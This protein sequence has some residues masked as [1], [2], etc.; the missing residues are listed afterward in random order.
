MDTTD[1]DRLLAA[2]ASVE[3]PLRRLGIYVETTTIVGTMGEGELGMPVGVI[4][5]LVGDAAFSQRVQDP[6]A[7]ATD[8]VFRQMAVEERKGEFGRTREDLERRLA[9][10]LPLFD[11]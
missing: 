10:G 6:A 8:Q 5:G 11:D 3:D 4:I 9:E 2:M 7:A 1:E